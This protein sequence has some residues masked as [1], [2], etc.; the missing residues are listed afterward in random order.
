MQPHRWQ[1]LTVSMVARLAVGAADRTVVERLVA[2]LTGTPSADGRAAE[3]APVDDPR[4]EWLCEA[5]HKR[6][7]RLLTVQ[8]IAAEIIDERDRQ[9]AQ[10]DRLDAELGRLLSQE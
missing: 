8:R 4:V 1:S 7:W 5:L 2:T 3:P 6:V 10:R 9:Q